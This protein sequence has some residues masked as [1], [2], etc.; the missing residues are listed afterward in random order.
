MKKKREQAWSSAWLA[1]LAAKTESM[2]IEERQRPCLEPLKN[3]E[4]ARCGRNSQSL[5]N[6]ESPCG[7]IMNPWKCSCWQRVAWW[8]LAWCPA[9]NEAYEQTVKQLAPIKK[10]R[11]I[12]WMW[13]PSFPFKDCRI[14]RACR[15]AHQERGPRMI[16][17]SRQG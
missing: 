15:R 6:L 12:Q 11:K 13:A 4:P 10:M 14:L 7:P 8:V 16:R 1:F 3:R 5:E 2:S 9:L 17:K